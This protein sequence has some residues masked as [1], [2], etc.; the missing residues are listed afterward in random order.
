M[1]KH[2]RASEEAQRR[3]HHACCFILCGLHICHAVRQLRAAQLCT[4]RGRGLADWGSK[5][6]TW[7]DLQLFK[8]HRH[9]VADS[10]EHIEHMVHRI[11]VDQVD[12][13]E[14]MPKTARS[15][16][17]L[18]NLHSSTRRPQAVPVQPASQACQH[19]V[20]LGKALRDGYSS[21]C[22]LAGGSPCLTVAAGLSG[23]GSL[24]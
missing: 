11:T 17:F 12:E 7:R 24:E 13:R 2:P 6:S 9:G 10:W 22:R 18:G 1:A 21:F 5:T 16:S 20:F 3:P 19:R 15:Q 23:P 4:K 8:Q 14:A